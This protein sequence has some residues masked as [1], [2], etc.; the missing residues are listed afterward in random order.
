M[1]YSQ[2]TVYTFQWVDLEVYKAYGMRIILLSVT[3]KPLIELYVENGEYNILK[4][5]KNILKK[6]LCSELRLCT[7]QTVSKQHFSNQV[8]KIKI[9]PPALSS[10]LLFTNIY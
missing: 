6:Y 4:F 3:Q 1:Y 2:R 7:W 5:F 10:S 8:E 9:F